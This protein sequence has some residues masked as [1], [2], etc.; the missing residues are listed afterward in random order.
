MPN[1]IQ[2]ITAKKKEHDLIVMLTAYDYPTARILDQ[3]GVDL[4][5]VGDSLANVALGLDSTKEVGM[6]EMLH[7]AKAVRRGVREALVIGDMPYESYQL[8]INSAVKHARSFIQEAGCD[9][10]K[11]EWFDSCLEVVQRLREDG[12]PVMGHI[13]LTPQTAEQLGGF[14]VQGRD[15]DSAQA[16]LANARALQ[17]AGCFSLVLE[18]V[19]SELAALITEK[20]SIPTIGIGA[21]N[22]CDGQVLV[23]QDILGLYDRF[24]PKFVKTYAQLSDQIGAV[25]DQFSVEVKSRAFPSVK[26]S[27]TMDKTV[28]QKLQE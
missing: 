6:F 24:K 11:V 20:V 14:K 17:T 25:I 16:L 5:L 13:G 4:I 18:C 2:Q 8:D 1:T 3:H 10:V 28:L 27:F 21:G 7:H 19:P 22:A 12:I 26:E 9:G 15:L 23:T